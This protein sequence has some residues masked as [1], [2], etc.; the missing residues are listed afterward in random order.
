VEL[1]ASNALVSSLTVQW[2]HSTKHVRMVV[3]LDVDTGV[4]IPSPPQTC[5]VLKQRSQRYTV[6]M[7]MG[8]FLLFKKQDYVAKD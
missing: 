7:S 5:V 6:P 8:T 3:L 2:Q 1:V 4:R